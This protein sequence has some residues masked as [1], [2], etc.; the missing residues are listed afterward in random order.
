MDTNSA[1]SGQTVLA[2]SKPRGRAK[3][4]SGGG[5]GAVEQVATSLP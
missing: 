5:R 3:L 1:V 2:V 4:R